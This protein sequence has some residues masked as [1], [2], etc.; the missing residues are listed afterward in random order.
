[1]PAASYAHT[2]SIALLHPF[3]LYQRTS[4]NARSAAMNE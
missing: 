3:R 1:M 2:Y 4:H